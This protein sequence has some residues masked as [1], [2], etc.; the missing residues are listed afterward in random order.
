MCKAFPSGARA[1]LPAK[2]KVRASV[3][4]SCF[5]PN[6]DAGW[7]PAAPNAGQRPALRCPRSVAR[8]PLLAL[9]L[10]VPEIKIARKKAFYLSGRLRFSRGP[11]PLSIFFRKQNTELYVHRNLSRQHSPSVPGAISRYRDFRSW[12]QT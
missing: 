11:I 10:N 5:T 3:V 7:K 9:H 2:V 12:K 6:Q 8:A 4:Q 1:S